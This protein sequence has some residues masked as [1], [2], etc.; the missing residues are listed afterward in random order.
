MTYKSNYTGNELDQSIADTQAAKNEPG[1]AGVLIKTD[2]FGRI[3]KFLQP[4]GIYGVR[5]NKSAS[6]FTR[7]YENEGKSAGSDFDG[8]GPWA[9]KRCNAADAG[10]INDYYGDPSFAYD[11]TNGQVMVEMPAFFYK[12][13]IP[14]SGYVD[15]L[16]S[17]TWREGFKRHPAFIRAGEVLTHIYP[18]AFE[19]HYNSG[20]AAMESIAGVVPSTSATNHDV[21]GAIDAYP[22]ATI[23]GCRGYAQAR[24]SNWEQ[25]DFWTH[26]AL[27]YLMLIEYATF[28]FQTAIAKGVVDRASG[29][30]HNGVITGETAG[31]DGGSDLG[32][33]SGASSTGN[34]NGYESISYRG[35]ENP[36]GNIWK[37]VDGLNIQ[38]DH[39]PWVADHSFASDT[40]TDPYVPVGV[41][42]PSSNGYG[43][44]IVLN[45]I[46]DAAFLTNAVAGSSSSGLYDYYYQNT[47]NRVAPVGGTWSYSAI[48]G[49]L[50]WNLIA[51]SGNSAR[52][53]GA[54]SLLLPSPYSR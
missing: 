44:D 26:N 51:S 52:A 32:N 29:T 41:T 14:Q 24:G 35:V 54:R 12:T 16:I 7:I 43:S 31:Q 15:F 45:D 1:T 25:Y 19:G 11:G 36:W 18:S 2:N 8:I 39:K 34:G 40:F 48:A 27:I 28:D 3:E 47:G 42:L 22:D 33:S 37:W 20:E 21:L 9:M 53:L 23:V 5:W 30:D 4:S 49:A 38:A 13:M 17:P 6:E 50:C 10:T 46:L